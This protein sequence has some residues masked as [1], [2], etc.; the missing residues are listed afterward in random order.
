MAIEKLGES[1]LQNVRDRN[2]QIARDNRKRKRK[3]D[4]Q[5]VFATV[6]IGIGN[7]YLADQTNKFLNSKEIYDATALHKSAIDNYAT[8]VNEMKTI[9]ESGKGHLQYEIDKQRELIRNL[10]ENQEGIGVFEK[11]SNEFNLH[12]EKLAREAAT[13]IVENRNKLLEQGKKLNTELFN[14]K[15]AN[16]INKAAPQNVG[17]LVSRRILNLFSGKNQEQV[18]EDARRDI[19]SSMQIENAKTYNTFKEQYQESKNY[20]TSLD[21]AKAMEKKE[22]VDFKDDSDKYQVPELIEKN[23]TVD[24]VSIP[25]FTIVDMEYSTKVENYKKV[26]DPTQLQNFIPMIGEENLESIKRKALKSSQ[27]PNKL[28]LDTLTNEGYSA[29]VKGVQEKGIQVGN[30]QTIENFDTSYEVYNTIIKDPN[31]LKNKFRDEVY[32][33]IL[34]SSLTANRKFNRM[35]ELADSPEETMSLVKTY[36]DI[37]K[38]LNLKNNIASQNIDGILNG[39]D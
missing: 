26:V 11:G 30:E 15:V 38:N 4:L 16:E 27:D 9:N 10:A 32:T 31:N 12:L 1:L 35:L 3:Q 19:L 34:T 25:H 14:S 24:G 29:Y 7:S 8:V 22:E 28:A 18:R 2:D 36:L 21:Y 6:A 23:I 33:R 37:G 5:D 13:P 39:N 20:S 17:Q